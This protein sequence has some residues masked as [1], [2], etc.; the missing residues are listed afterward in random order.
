MFVVA[1]IIV[2]VVAINVRQREN[3]GCLGPAKAE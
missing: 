1:L 3:Y 2:F